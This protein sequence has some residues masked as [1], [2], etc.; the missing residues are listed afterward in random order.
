[1]NTNRSKATS[2]HAA[3]LETGDSST[4]S[5]KGPIKGGGIER[6]SSNISPSQQMLNHQQEQKKKAKQA[7]HMI[8]QQA[9]TIDEK[10]ELESQY[11]E[12]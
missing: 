3:A 6:G 2:N 12:D 11:E 4:P 1:L 7:D 10:A 9:A 8:A 5:H